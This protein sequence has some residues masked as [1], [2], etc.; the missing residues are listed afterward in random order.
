ME[1]P[2][3]SGQHMTLKE[4]SAELARRLMRLFLRDEQG[5]RPLNGGNQLFQRDP[6]WRDYILFHEYF[7]GDN[8]AGIGATHQTGWTGL[9]AN[10]IQHLGE[11][12]DIPPLV[13]GA[14]ARE[15]TPKVPA[16]V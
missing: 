11:P 4:V 2:T 1:C 16:G 6:Q 7:H 3:G 15:E 8:G 5:N 12:F 14:S 13:V 10:L 9:V